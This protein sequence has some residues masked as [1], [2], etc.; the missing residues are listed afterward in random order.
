[1]KRFLL[2]AF[3]FLTLFCGPL[4]AADYPRPSGHINDFANIIPAETEAIL[5]LDLQNYRRDTSIEIAIVTVSS[6]GGMSVEEY[7]IE[8]AS[9]WGVGA[10][11]KDNGLV[12]LIAPNERKAR[13]EVG[14]GLE[15]DLTDAQANRIMQEI[16]IPHFKKGKMAEGI[17]M[18]LSGIFKELGTIPYETRLEEKRLAAEKEAAERE[19]SSALLKSVLIWG[20]VALLI[21]GPFYMIFSA[22]RK[23]LRR[24]AELRALHEKNGKAIKTIS[25][26][27]SE[28]EREYL[29]A[30]NVIS[31]MQKEYPAEV[32]VA[33]QDELGDESYRLESMN[34]AKDAAVKSH[35]GGWKEADATALLV[36]N[37]LK[38]SSVRASFLEKVNDKRYEQQ[39]ARHRAETVLSNFPRNRARVMAAIKRP[40]V[41][42]AAKQDLASAETIFENC[43]KKETSGLLNW[44]AFCGRVLEAEALL[45]KAENRALA[46]IEFAKRARE[47]GPALMNEL[48]TLLKK[49]EDTVNNEDV[50]A[51]TK[52]LASDAR[53]TYSSAKEIL[54]TYEGVPS[55]E[56]WV[57]VFAA[58]LAAKKLVENALTKAASE[59]EEAARKKRRARENS[60]AASRG[61]SASTWSS[62]GSSSSSD[63][64]GGFG[65]GSFGGGGASGSW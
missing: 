8:L 47:E 36:Q 22:I 64:F 15:G 44:V 38:T 32:W 21:L 46:D 23:C 57:P 17:V 12:F 1:M 11:K 54:S 10:R 53:Q 7:A 28:A 37:L 24:R 5:E 30:K 4:S 62:S 56:Y 2:M 51:G 19:R 20:I 3:A 35:G 60:A 34:L 59:M 52:S 65:G 41:T 25:E 55:C 40:D 6:L 33:L 49:A 43:R 45:S 50:T 31:E 13:I 61:S 42:A 39:K 9:A 16:V 27:I 58:A 26:N 63:S 18:G 29:P 14:Y 48:P